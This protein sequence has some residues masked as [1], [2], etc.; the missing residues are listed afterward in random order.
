MTTKTFILNT[1]EFA[2]VQ[3]MITVAGV[4]V[5]LVLGWNAEFSADTTFAAQ[6]FFAGM[7]ARG[8]IG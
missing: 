7:Y 1:M 8:W 3:A 6:M 2:G 5:G 4:V